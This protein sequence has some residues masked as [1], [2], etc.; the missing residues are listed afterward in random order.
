MWILV[1]DVLVIGSLVFGGYMTRMRTNCKCLLESSRSSAESLR[2]SSA[3][4]P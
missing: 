2:K 4:I 3:Q 1:W